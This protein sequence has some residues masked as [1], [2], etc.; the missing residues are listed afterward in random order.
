MTPRFKHSLTFAACLL[1]SGCDD[2]KAPEQTP[3]PTQA[4]AKTTDSK[5]GPPN[6]DEPAPAVADSG[7]TAETEPVDATTTNKPSGVELPEKLGLDTT[8]PTLSFADEVTKAAAAELAKEIDGLK[9]P[10]RLVKVEANALAFL[11]LAHTADDV[12]EATAALDAI[13][14]RYSSR[15]TNGSRKVDA[16]YHAVVAYR[17]ASDDA[18]ILTA[19]FGAAKHSAETVPPDEKVLGILVDRAHHHPSLSGRFLALD[20]LHRVRAMSGAIQ[21][22]FEHALTE[23]SPQFLALTLDSMEHTGDKMAKRDA[24]EQTVVAFTKHEEVSVRG[25]AVAVLANMRGSDEQRDRIASVLLPLLDDPAP[26]VRAEA[27]YAMGAMRR[28]ETAAKLVE[29][30]DDTGA[31]RLDVD[32][33]TNIDGSASR[34]TLGVSMSNTV[35]SVAVMAL[36]LLSTTTDAEFEFAQD[37]I[38]DGKGGE[39]YGPAIEKAKTWYAANKAKLRSK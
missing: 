33:W 10:Y 11:H 8:R 30:L 39:D 25:A 36:S 37:I 24:F 12:A 18:N 7:G 29:L 23:T 34:P 19:A 1:V 31:T 3:T 35:G 13:A 14:T 17:L 21:A 15:N 2:A 38:R 27:V 32:G 26:S 22:A 16:N 28:V 9:F 4:D 6:T 5:P 20:V